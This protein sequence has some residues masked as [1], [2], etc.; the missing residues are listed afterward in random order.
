MGCPRIAAICQHEINQATDV[1]PPVR[2]SGNTIWTRKADEQ[3]QHTEA[4]MIATLKQ[5]EAGRKVENVAREQGVSKHT[6]YAGRP[7]T[8]AWM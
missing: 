1:T 7:S 3:E 5:V 4:A 8:A 2:P 6:V